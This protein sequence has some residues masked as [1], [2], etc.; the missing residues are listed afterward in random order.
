MR[1]LATRDFVIASP[2]S[3]FPVEV[4]MDSWNSVVMLIANGEVTIA[5]A[6]ILIDIPHEWA[7]DMKREGVEA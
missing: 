7:G 5:K 1:V 2:T 3:G 4:P 6:P